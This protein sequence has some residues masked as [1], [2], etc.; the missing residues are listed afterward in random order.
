MRPFPSTDF[1]FVTAYRTLYPVRVNLCA[2]HFRL[3]APREKHVD[4]VHIHGLAESETN[5]R[6]AP[7]LAQGLEAAGFGLGKKKFQVIV[8]EASRPRRPVRCRPGLVHARGRGY[9]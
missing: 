5:I 2:V 3:L 1:D 8:I 9:V 6:R 4:F 7:V